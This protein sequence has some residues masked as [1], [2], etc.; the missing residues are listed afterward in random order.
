MLDE[1]RRT[2]S[3][4]NNSMDPRNK[5]FITNGIKRMDGFYSACFLAFASIY[6]RQQQQQQQHKNASDK[7]KFVCARVFS[8]SICG[9]W[10][11]FHLCFC[12]A[13]LSFRCNWDTWYV[14]YARMHWVWLLER[15][16]NRK[17]INHAQTLYSI[18][19]QG[20]YCPLQSSE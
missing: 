20:H 11:N 3:S 13:N 15:P 14:L 10:L 17:E 16:A 5:R 19:I 12:H 9:W 6:G 4:N 7:F 2:R 1:V 8:L 18:R